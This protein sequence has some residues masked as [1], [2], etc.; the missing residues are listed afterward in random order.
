MSAMKT[1]LVLLAPLL[2]LAATAEE[3]RP[4]NVVLIFTDDQGYGDLSCFGSKTIDTPHLDALAEGGLKL[5]DF[6]VPS[7]VCSPSRAG[8]LTGCYPKRVGMHRHVVFPKD[9]YGLHPDELTLADHLKAHG[10][11]TACVGKWHLGHIEPTLPTAHG[12]DSYF[13]IPYSNDMSHPDNQGKP[14]HDLDAQWRAQ[15]E[16][17]PKWG[18][19]L[20][21]D[22][23]IVEHP[24]NQRTITRRYTDEAIAFIEKNRE[25]PFFLYLP[26][27]MP[28]IPLFV[29]E[30]VLDP[31]PANAYIN[32]IEHIDAEC[33]RIID[34]LEQLGLADN[35]YVIFT[36]DNG[37][38]LRFD[39]HGGSAG[40]L[41]AG[42]GTTFEGGQR[43]PAIIR[44]PGIAPGGESDALLSTIDLLPTFATLSGHPLEAPRPIDGLDV[45]ATLTDG[46][47]SPREEF[48]HY[49]SRGDIEGLR[50]GDW[51]LLV[52]R[53]RKEGAKENVMLFNLAD[54]L[55][56]QTNLAAKHPDKVAT[57]RARMKELD[58]EI[59]SSARS[60]YRQ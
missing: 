22:T 38:W 39:N 48:L 44:G 49:S 13:G 26:H 4:P 55:G 50:Q 12:F 31:D 6:H 32:T 36:T 14:G 5:T 41:R 45:S 1:L 53:P 29:P 46:A 2:V 54:D 56:E 19:P 40:P 57:L 15:D 24:V 28:H 34:R 33:G 30:D 52:H 25:Q 8:L 27:S 16:F 42:K 58:G 21:R 37:P 9:R 11:A 43:V 17:W 35:T 60:A 51:K 7:P 59:T 20:M 47:P 10:Y 23:E 3:G 18:T